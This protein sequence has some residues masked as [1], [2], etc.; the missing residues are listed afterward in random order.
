VSESRGI[1]RPRVLEVGFDA[2]TESQSNGCILWM[3]ARQAK[4][5]GEFSLHGVRWSTHRFAWTRAN[6]P[7]PKDM[8][9]LHRCDTPACVNP[10]HLFLGTNAD[11]HADKV[12][13]G[14]QHKGHVGIL[15]PVAVMT[16]N[17]VRWI[18]FF[19]FIGLNYNRIA[20]ILGHQRGSI[21]SVCLGV[22]WKHVKPF[23]YS[24]MEVC[25]F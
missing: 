23:D 19:R 15:S 25:H 4:G 9:V 2:L 17:D 24:S 14:R 12:A 21:R 5:Y 18:H 7:I 13:K 22:T 1:N 6:G 16:D 8:H 11:N 10:E 20:K 3:G